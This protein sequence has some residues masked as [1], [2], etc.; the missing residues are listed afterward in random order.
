MAEP[1]RMGRRGNDKGITMPKKNILNQQ[2]STVT[3][4][5]P[6]W[7]RVLKMHWPRTEWINE[8]DFDLA[9]SEIEKAT[10]RNP[11]SEYELKQVVE[12]MAG[13]DSKQKYAPTLREFIIS[14][15]IFR[16]REN[17][18]GDTTMAGNSMF[19]ENVK[20]AMREAKDWLT[21]WNIMCQ[22][23]YYAGFS[24]DPDCDETNTI[25]SWALQVW[26]EWEDETHK[27][28]CRMARDLR[29]ARF[30]MVGGI[31][32]ESHVDPNELTH[33]ERLPF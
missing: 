6:D 10:D 5:L 33:T 15:Y 23:S 7:A 18:G 24:R 30:E 27:I 16:K 2:T 19:V 12:W 26:R 21:R 20:R 13:P 31:R 29:A 17:G 11:P 3:S 28:K 4:N 1:W 32:N 22:P 8:Q 25:N 14:I 9:I